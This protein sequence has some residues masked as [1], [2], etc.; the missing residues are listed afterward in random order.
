M[1]R[2]Q[3]ILIGLRY[4]IYIAIFVFF[5]ACV[6]GYASGLAI[7]TLI[8]KAL[9]AGILFGLT[10]FVM[11]KILVKFVPENIGVGNSKDINNENKGAAR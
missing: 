2:H 11:L 9:I 10:S 4:S 5:L 1:I 3:L 8:Q 6:L 7:E